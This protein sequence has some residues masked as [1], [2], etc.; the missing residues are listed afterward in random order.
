MS[1][2]RILVCEDDPE[3]VAAVA[4]ALESGGFDVLPVSH[5][6]AAW[7]DTRPP[8]FALLDIS[9]P[10]RNDMAL[11]R[12]LAHAHIP[13]IVLSARHD[14]T[15]VERAIEAGAM[16]CFFKP[17]DVAVIVPSIRAWIACA[18]ELSQ[19]RREQR[20][21][22]AALHHRRSV[23]TAVGVIMERHGLTPVDAF[24]ALRRHARSERQSVA[25]LASAIVAGAALPP[26]MT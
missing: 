7:N 9:P 17:V 14:T 6:G 4:L 20:T 5:A 11:A 12:Q 26:S 22:L 10:H 18:S 8:D 1:K 23:G 21:L 25:S 19:L 16:G 2:P 24:E 13:F 15:L 3:V